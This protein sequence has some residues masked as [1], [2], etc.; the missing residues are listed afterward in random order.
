MPWSGSS[1]IKK[2]ARALADAE[3]IAHH[4]AKRRVTAQS[5]RGRTRCA[6]VAIASRSGGVGVSTITANLAVCMAA[7]GLRVLVVDT[8]QRGFGAAAVLAAAGATQQAPKA[9]PGGG[10]LS[11]ILASTGAA[12][13]MLSDDQGALVVGHRRWQAAEALG[14]TSAVVVPVNGYGASGEYDIV[15]V[16]ASLLQF[17]AVGRRETE[18]ADRVIV[19]VPID[20]SDLVAIE[21]EY[22][23]P[24]DDVDGDDDDD[25]NWRIVAGEAYAAGEVVRAVVHGRHLQD[26]SPHA[27]VITRFTEFPVDPEQGAQINTML[28]EID[29]PVLGSWIEP[30]PE[31]RAAPVC[32]LNPRHPAATSYM[33]VAE[34]ILGDLGL[35]AVR[36]PQD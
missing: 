1:K 35:A 30:H 14:M 19:P 3:G 36:S 2:L 21:E 26:V 11:V 27:L 13:P 8:A 24:D 16:D 4:E 31:H 9:F 5:P 6:Q 15:L 23:G 29:L 34:Q 32:L 33:A 7:K 17:N 18:R 10:T 12:E 28:E 20:Q 22:L 25:L